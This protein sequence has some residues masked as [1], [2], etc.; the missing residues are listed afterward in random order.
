MK[1]RSPWDTY[2]DAITKASWRGDNSHAGKYVKVLLAALQ[3]S[4]EHKTLDARLVEALYRISEFY[5]LEHDYARAESV[6]KLILDVQRQVLG[7]NDPRIVDTV[8]RIA[9][10]TH[11]GKQAPVRFHVAV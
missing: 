1:R 11:L 7:E 9:R 6:C 4:A 8:A 5:C 2:V 3:E 10:L